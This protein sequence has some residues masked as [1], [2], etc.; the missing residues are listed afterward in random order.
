MES[1]LKIEQDIIWFI[2]I[3]LY[4]FFGASGIEVGTPVQD[5]ARQLAAAALGLPL[6]GVLVTGDE[7]TALR[8]ARANASHKRHTPLGLSQNGAHIFILKAVNILSM[9]W[10]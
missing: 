5:Q 6:Q 1:Y 2:Q 9:Y 7:R 3:M 8:G 10:Y 4:I